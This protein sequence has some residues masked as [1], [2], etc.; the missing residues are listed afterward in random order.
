MIC[1]QQ[2]VAT[3]IVSRIPCVIHTSDFV[4]P[5]PGM[6]FP[7]VNRHLVF[8]EHLLCAGSLSVTKDKIT[9][10]A[11]SPCPHEKT[12]KL[13]KGKSIKRNKSV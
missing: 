3:V 9:C 11:D 7:S 2:W 6:P 12:F 5:L 8:V 1:G 13:I 10:K 4:S